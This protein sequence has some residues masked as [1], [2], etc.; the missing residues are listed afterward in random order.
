M[1]VAEKDNFVCTIKTLAN[2]TRFLSGKSSSLL[3]INVD[4]RL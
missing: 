1:R 2:I 3:K 4:L